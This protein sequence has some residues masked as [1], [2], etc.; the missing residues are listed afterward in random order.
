MSNSRARDDVYETPVLDVLV[1]DDEEMVLSVI[2]RILEAHGHQVRIAKDGREALN[3]MRATGSD[4]VISD[5]R[6]P[7]MNGLELAQQIRIR[8]P[9]THVVLMTGYSLDK[10]CQEAAKLNVDGYLHKPFKAREL[11]RVLDR[12][13]QEQT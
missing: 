10:S 4:L 1:V 9:A 3:A 2:G 8:F 12:I 13:V 5:I 7:G 6:M 11:T